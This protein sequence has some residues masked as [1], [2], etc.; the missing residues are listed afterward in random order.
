MA[1]NGREVLSERRLSENKGG[2]DR[3]TA[4]QSHEN[5]NEKAQM[6]KEPT[7]KRQPKAETNGQHENAHDEH[8]PNE[9][10]E[11]KPLN[12]HPP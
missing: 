8:N 3:T 11:S 5:E 10:N 7:N 4:T 1:W 2:H 6:A 9:R 12:R